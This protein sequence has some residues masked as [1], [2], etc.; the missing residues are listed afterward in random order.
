LTIRRLQSIERLRFSGIFERVVTDTQPEPSLSV[1]GAL[2]VA[3]FHAGLGKFV[4]PSVYRWD[5]GHRWSVQEM[6][7]Y[8][9]LKR[10]GSA[11]YGNYIEALL[12]YTNGAMPK[13][14]TVWSCYYP[15]VMLEW[16]P[17]C[18]VISTVHPRG[19]EKCVNVVEFYYPEEVAGFERELVELH[20]QAYMESA[21]ED[22]QI[23]T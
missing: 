9:Q 7:I 6:G 5:F 21:I 2:H 12:R 23:C 13:Y 10:P 22:G 14:G 18:Q 11:A 19:A 4:D 15:N 17:F 1:S 16:Y 20:R 8:Q 3:P